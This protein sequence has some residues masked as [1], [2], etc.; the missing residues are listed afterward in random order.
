MCVYIYT[1]SWNVILLLTIL[2]TKK[3][4]LKQTL[5]KLKDFSIFLFPPT[6]NPYLTYKICIYWTQAN[7]CPHQS[8]SD[9]FGCSENFGFSSDHHFVLVGSCQ[10]SRAYL[11]L[12]QVRVTSQEPTTPVL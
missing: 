5:V 3:T 1:Q 7:S 4:Q 2:V 8:T 6:I 11:A 10:V 12:C 9:D